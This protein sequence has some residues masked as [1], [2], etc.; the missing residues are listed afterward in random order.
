MALNRRDLLKNT[1]VASLAAALGNAA[2]RS[3]VIRE[4]NE[5]PGTGDWILSNTRVDPQTKYRSP[6]IE[7]YC[8]RT[9]VRPGETIDFKVSANPAST[10][11]ID[12]YRMGYYGG[13][14]ARHLDRLG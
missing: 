14:G 6:S 2:Q 3:D 8:S 4:E 1:A 10:F 11:T 13:L 9:S 5:R 12:L 7:G